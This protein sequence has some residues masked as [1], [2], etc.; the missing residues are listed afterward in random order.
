MSFFRNSF[1]NLYIHFFHILYS[2]IYF[3]YSYILLVHFI[4]INDINTLPIFLE[5]LKKGNLSDYY[6]I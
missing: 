5:I 2:Y 1:K 6:N 3:F 4:H